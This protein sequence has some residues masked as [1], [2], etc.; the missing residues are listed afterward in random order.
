[1]LKMRKILFVDDEPCVIRGFKRMLSPLCNKWGME[2]AISGKEA[3]NLMSKTS[4]DVV[5]SDMRMPVMDGIKF[6]DT[7]MDRYP[8]TVRIILSGH[9]DR[10]MILRSVKCAHQFLAKPSNADTIVY[11][12]ERTCK[13]RELL[14]ND[15]LQKFVTGIKDLPS[16]PGL[17]DIIVREMQYP[18]PSIRKI[19]YIISQDVSMSAKVLQLVNSAFFGLPEKIRDPQQATIRLGI[20]TLRALVLSNHIFSS[21][22]EGSELYGL[23]L[24]DMWK[25]SLMTGRLAKDIARAVSG[26]KEIAEEALIAGMFHD[27]GKLIL[28]KVPRQYKMVEEFIEKNGCDH[29]EA[30]YTVLKTS[31]AE[32]G[33]YLL[34][35]WGIPDNIVEAVAFHHNPSKLLDEMFII[36]GESLNG[37][38][39]LRSDKNL[40]TSFTTVTAVHVANALMMQKDCS[41]DTTYFPYIDMG[42]LKA[43]NLTDKL[44]GWV[45][46]HKKILKEEV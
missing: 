32:M 13:L 33:S 36:P 31:H 7:V 43:F 23:P 12:I 45:E 37:D 5:V 42:Y 16:F 1:M 24:L 4:F 20:D 34:G 15:I 29:V 2:F 41:S 27:I 18:E 44:S 46:Y 21:F 6:L 38:L 14:R 3:M 35:L 22:P 17:Y 11:T 30:E 39:K 19:G 8:E 40:L 25:H 10:E 26:D 28:Q 9:S